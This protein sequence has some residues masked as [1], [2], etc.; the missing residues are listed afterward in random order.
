ME[1]SSQRKPKMRRLGDQLGRL[2]HPHRRRARARRLGDLGRAG[3]VPRGARR[4]DAVPLLIAIPTAI[5]GS[6]SLAARR[7]IIVKD[8]GTLETISTCRTIIFDKTGTLTYGRPS[9]TEVLPAAGVNGDDVLGLVAALERYSK[10]PLAGALVREAEKRHLASHEPNEVGETPGR[11]APRARRWTRGRRHRQPAAAELDPPPCPSSPAGSSASFSSTAVRRPHPVP[12]RAP[13]ADGAAFIRHLSR[14]HGYEKVMLV[15]GDRASGRRST[16]PSGSASPRSA[17]EQSPEQKVEIVRAE[18]E[19]ARTCFVGDGIN[20]APALALA[21][22][23]I[24]FGQA[25]DVTTEAAGVV[26]L[27]N[28]LEKVDEFFHIS[29][30]SRRIALQKPPWAA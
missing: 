19:R 21:H 11:G 9:V 18:S 6:V 8:P 1:A 29:H 5:I 10:H 7:G 17:P 22:V 27:D 30:R 13:R 20:D 15:S 4:R 25:S 2:V 24:A 23:G 26:V 12:R 3:A 28:S 14:K 16:S